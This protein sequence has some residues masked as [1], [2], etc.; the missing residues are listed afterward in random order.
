[1]LRNQKYITSKTLETFLIQIFSYVKNNLSLFF[2][3]KFG[4]T[5]FK[6]KSTLFQY[7]FFLDAFLMNRSYEPS[8]NPKFDKID[9]NT[10]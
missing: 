3:F 4:Y 2:V 6:I 8:P 5:K 9:R 10:D 1:M 7:Y